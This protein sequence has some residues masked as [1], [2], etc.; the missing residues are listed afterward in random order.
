MQY[1]FFGTPRFG[2]LVL[3]RLITQGF[4][5]KLVV[6][7][8][9][10]P[11][12]RNQV[13]TAPAVKRIAEQYGI[14]VRQ[15]EKLSMIYDELRVINADFFLVAAYGK[16]LRPELLGLA[17]LGTVGVHPSL[18]PVYRGPSPLQQSILDGVTTTGVSLFL[19]DAEVDHGPV[20]TQATYTIPLWTTYLDLE[21]HLA[22]LG[23]DLVREILPR[24][25]A[26][27]LVPEEQDHDRAT[28]THKFLTKDAYIP[29]DLLVRAMN[30]GQDASSLA[31]MI[32]GLNPEPGVWTERDGIR[33]KLLG[34]KVKDDRLIVTC[35]Q[36]AGKKI[37]ET[38]LETS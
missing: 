19:V 6:C 30:Q 38:S 31:H 21:E 2:A 22:F 36:V 37:Q 24:W 7:N 5:P 35:Y 13:L 27:D 20:I 32:L 11:T 8:P 25:I 34:A 26:G 33:V 15:P 23:A 4:P 14:P 10:R 17:R 28:F 16:I 12:G 18:L 29:W 3:E 9:D 1:V